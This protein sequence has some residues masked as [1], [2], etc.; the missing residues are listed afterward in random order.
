MYTNLYRTLLQAL[1]KVTQYNSCLRLSFPFRFLVPTNPYLESLVKQNRCKFRGLCLHSTSVVILPNN[2]RWNQEFFRQTTRG[3]LVVN[4]QSSI[5][6]N[7][8]NNY[9]FNSGKVQ[10]LGS[11]QTEHKKTYLFRSI[12]EGTVLARDLIL[13]RWL[14]LCTFKLIP[15]KECNS[16][17]VNCCSHTLHTTRPHYCTNNFY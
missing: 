17:T 9:L 15:V 13:Q 10:S 1:I 14:H 16:L 11:L 8:F 12:S 3:Q 6:H 2:F 4:S 5:S 7:E